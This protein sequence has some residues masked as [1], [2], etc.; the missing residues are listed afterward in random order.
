M[1]IEKYHS[2]FK[3]I[4]VNELFPFTDAFQNS[5]IR[6]LEARNFSECEQ[7]QSVIDQLPTV[8]DIQHTIDTNFITLTSSNEFSAQ[9]DEKLKQQL[10]KLHPWRKGPFKIFNQVIDTE[11]RSDVKWRRIAPHISPLQGRMVLDVGCGSGYH[12]WRMRGEG[13][14]FVVGIDPMLKFLF[15]FEVIKH[16]LAEEPVFI[17][18]LTCEELPPTMQCFDTVFSM[19]VLYHRKSPFE[20]LEELKQALRPGGELVL[21]TLVIDGDENSVLIPKDRYAQMRNVW[22]LP[23]TKAMEKWLARAGFVDIKTVDVSITTDEEQRTTAWMTFHSLSDFLDPEDRS[24]TI[25]GYSAPK[26]ATFIARKP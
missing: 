1:N 14:R 2:F 4:T 25:E 6:R 8:K 7:W 16:Y 17:L 18:P 5:I 10:L 22:F 12:C 3:A 9:D 11:W 23:S 26:R 15:Q 13:A 24:K 19:G 21:E 20:H